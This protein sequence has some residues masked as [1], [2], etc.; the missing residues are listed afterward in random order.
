M[1]CGLVPV[2]LRGSKVDAVSRRSV[3]HTI[4]RICEQLHA[5]F[6]L[7]IQHSWMSEENYMQVFSQ[8]FRYPNGHAINTKAIAKTIT[9]PFSCNSSMLP[10]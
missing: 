5:S 6:I 3:Q 9:K 8:G 4:A 2:L 1:T 10:E 7:T